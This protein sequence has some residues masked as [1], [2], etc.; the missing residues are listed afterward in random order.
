MEA[1]L[2]TLPRPLA[3]CSHSPGSHHTML[4]SLGPPHSPSA[5][6][7]P[8][9]F[10]S[11]D[12]TENFGTPRGDFHESPLSPPPGTPARPRS[13]PVKLPF[14]PVVVTPPPPEPRAPDPSVGGDEASDGEVPPGDTSFVAAAPPE[15]PPELPM[16]GAASA[17]FLG[18]STCV[19]G[20]GS[21]LLSSSCNS[22]PHPS[23]YPPSPASPSPHCCIREIVDRVSARSDKLDGSQHL[24]LLISMVLCAAL[25]VGW[26][27]FVWQA[28]NVAKH[29][30][31]SPRLVRAPLS[32]HISAL[33]FSHP[34]LTS[35]S[36]CAY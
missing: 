29:V 34:F 8:A 28:A 31:A 26:L 4:H 36:M 2:L 24:A 12:P 15:P 30:Y 1:F 10:R 11:S 3:L 18:R 27:F 20:A 22:S 13:S 25:L 35:F 7:R 6:T 14:S 23:S 19:V 21:L 32:I 9:G 16:L 17:R 5:S 33:F